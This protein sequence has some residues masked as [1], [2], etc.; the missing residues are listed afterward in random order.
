MKLVDTD[1][2]IIL[3]FLH[4]SGKVSLYFIPNSSRSVTAFTSYHITFD[5]LAANLVE[6]V[7]SFF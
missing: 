7:M 4:L 3:Y 6:L 2:F 1:S 5:S